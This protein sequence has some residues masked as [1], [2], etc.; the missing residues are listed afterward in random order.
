MTHPPDNGASYLGVYGLA[1][2]VVCWLIGKGAGELVALRPSELLAP[3]RA[4]NC[5]G[6]HDAP[7]PMLYRPPWWKCY[8]HDETV[9]VPMQPRLQDIPFY[10]GG[11]FQALSKEVDLVYSK[12]GWEKTATWKYV[13]R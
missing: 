6:D 11:V 2:P 5:P 10:D 8:R 1:N 7:T 13:E 9:A 3:Q 4:P 12:E